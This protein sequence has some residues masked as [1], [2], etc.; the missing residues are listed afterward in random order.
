MIT[1]NRNNNKIIINDRIIKHKIISDK[2]NT[3]K[4]AIAS[5][6]KNKVHPLLKI[7]STRREIFIIGIPFKLKGI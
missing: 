5:K 6:H 1:N 3:L 4:I 2:K 7:V